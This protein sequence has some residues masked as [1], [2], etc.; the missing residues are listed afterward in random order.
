[1]LTMRTQSHAAVE[2][3]LRPQALNSPHFEVPLI[4]AAILD[5]SQLD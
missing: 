3:G 4:N 1:M 2:C 5:L